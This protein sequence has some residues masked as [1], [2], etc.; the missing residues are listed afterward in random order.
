MDPT[1]MGTAEW[2]QASQILR[3]FFSTLLFIIGFAGNLLLAH[4]FLPSLVGT[5]HLP[6]AVMSVRPVL[7]VMSI[8]CLGVAAYFFFRMVEL[9]GLFGVV[10]PTRWWM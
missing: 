7:Y 5:G 3:F 4:A 1:P 6:K 10:Y 9:R 2:S 8:S